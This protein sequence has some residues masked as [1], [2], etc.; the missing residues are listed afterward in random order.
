M[1]RRLAY[2][3]ALI[4]LAPACATQ[5]YHPTKTAAEMQADIKLCSD[6]A[7]RRFWMDPVA[8]LYNA[9][10]CLEAKGY[11]RAQAEAGKK[12]ERAV[13]R[14]RKGLAPGEVCRVPCR[15]PGG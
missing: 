8:A 15:T 3:A 1:L 7:N 4:L 5:V 10:D 14:S 11:S 9:Y 2:P 13:A 12:V 6:G